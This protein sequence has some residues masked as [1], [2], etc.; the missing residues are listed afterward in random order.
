MPLPCREPTPTS[1]C[2]TKSTTLSIP[3][4]T[5]RV[6]I[7]GDD[8]YEHGF[9]VGEWRHP[10]RVVGGNEASGVHFIVR[11]TES[12]STA[13]EHGARRPTR[14]THVRPCRAVGR[15]SSPRAKG[16][17]W[18]LIPVELISCFASR[19]HYVCKTASRLAPTSSSLKE[20]PPFKPRPPLWHLAPRMLNL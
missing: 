17:E 11:W 16:G 10:N 7:D 12:M 3:S 5:S 20:C 6:N 2:S 15:R 8:R 18:R 9:H 19:G 13:V 14:P 4:L 1:T